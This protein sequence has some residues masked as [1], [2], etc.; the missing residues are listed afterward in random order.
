VSVREVMYLLRLLRQL[1]RL[2]LPEKNCQLLD[3][4]VPLPLLFPLQ[5]GEKKP[6]HLGFMSIFLEARHWAHCRELPL[7]A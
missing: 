2:I 6:A 7:K 5:V 1:A 3:G 4:S